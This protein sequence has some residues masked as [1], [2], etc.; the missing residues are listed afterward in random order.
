M[1]DAKD[2]PSLR[3]GQR[4]L[5]ARDGRVVS[6]ASH[7]R[8]ILAIRV[9]AGAAAASLAVLNPVVGIPLIAG[10]AIPT[11]AVVRWSRQLRAAL[12]LA[13]DDRLDEASRALDALGAPLLVRSRR[14]ANVAQLRSFIAE[15]R[16]DL[17]AAVAHA[18]DCARLLPSPRKGYSI[19]YWTNQYNRAHWLI[20][21]GRTDD[22][23][24]QLAA[25]GRA[26]GGEWYRVQYRFLVLHAAFAKLAE[27]P[28]D[29]KLGDWLRDALRYNHTGGTLALLGWAFEARGDAD[30]AQLAYSEAPSRFLK[31]PAFFAR[32]YPALWKTLGPKLDAATAAAEQIN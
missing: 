30:A 12:R 4:I 23:R 11:I 10:V 5:I 7:R 15:R 24:A 27:L 14:L 28:D 6:G 22:A 2:L 29:D 19:V 18:D 17:A 26:P 21:L 20:E 16:G 3:P 8:R 31:G 32:G 25:C 9:L 1:S 13:L